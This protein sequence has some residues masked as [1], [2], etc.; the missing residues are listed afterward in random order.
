[1]GYLYKE[2][3]VKNSLTSKIAEKSLSKSYRSYIEILCKFDFFNPSVS[4]LGTQ[5]LSK[6]P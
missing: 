4:A 2:I 1:M 3:V 6:M 5:G